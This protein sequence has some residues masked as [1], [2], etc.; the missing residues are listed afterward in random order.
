MKKILLFL[1]TLLTLKGFSQS[2]VTYFERPLG[3]IYSKNSWANLNDFTVSGG[4][5]TVSGGK[6]LCSTGSGFGQ[7]LGLNQV[8]M[9]NDWQ[10]TIVFHATSVTGNGIAIGKNSTAAYGQNVSWCAQ[11][12][13]TG[14]NTFI[15]IGSQ[16]FLL[17]YGQA[18][19]RIPLMQMTGFE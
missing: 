3:V 13:G 8:S 10:M 16:S 19:K 5:W 1:F 4:T 15:F 18:H 12:V 9:L 2:A 14:G 6:I 17:L 11:N 7:Y